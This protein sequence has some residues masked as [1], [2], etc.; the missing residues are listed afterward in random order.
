MSSQGIASLPAVDV[1]EDLVGPLVAMHSDKVITN[2][3]DEMVLE[4]P[5]DDL[6]Q[7]VGCEQLVDIR[8]RQ[9]F[10]EWLQC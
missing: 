1:V 3:R 4:R 5:L 7:K 2:P 8:T 10:G 6:V 9:V